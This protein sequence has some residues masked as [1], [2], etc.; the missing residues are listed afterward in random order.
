LSVHQ[1]MFSMIA[2]AILLGTV[3]CLAA[4]LDVKRAVEDNG[5]ATLT[6][7]NVDRAPI[8][9][10]SIQINHSKKP[11]CNLMA[12]ASDYDTSFVRSDLFG[13]GNVSFPDQHMVESVTL[14][15][16]ETVSALVYRGC[17]TVLAVDISTD[18]GI[19]SFGFKP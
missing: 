19:G 9:I 16:G 12:V 13:K 18:A 10:R 7:V 15:Y 5:N 4:D 17:G 8:T 3:P 14:A 2:T 11:V 6:L 1:T